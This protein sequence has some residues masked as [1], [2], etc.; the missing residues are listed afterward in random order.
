MR[1][2]ESSKFYFL[3]EE[4]CQSPRQR[5]KFVPLGAK[6]DSEGNEVMWVSTLW[7]ISGKERTC[8]TFFDTKNMK[9]KSH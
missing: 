3:E 5:M 2:N 1:E 6:V 8:A 7:K 9:M 4:G